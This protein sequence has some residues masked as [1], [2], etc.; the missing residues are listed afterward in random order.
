M[1]A[2]KPVESIKK[3]TD[4]KSAGSFRNDGIITLNPHTALNQHHCSAAAAVFCQVLC[5]KHG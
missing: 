4:I 2:D 1:A 5:K 3:P